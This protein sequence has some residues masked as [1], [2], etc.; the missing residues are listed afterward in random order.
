MHAHA[1][2]S[3]LCEVEVPYGLEA[4]A[5]DE[6]ERR[7]G[8]RVDTPYAVLQSAMDG[9]IRFLYTGDLM[10]LLTL[11]TVQTAS[12]VLQFAGPRP[13]ALLGDAAIR[14]MLQLI[15][16]IRGLWP[17][18]AFATLRLGTAGAESAVMTRLRRTLAAASGLTETTGSGD[19]EIRV[20]RSTAEISGWDVLI[21]VSPRPLATRA[22]RVCNMPGA[23]NAATARAMVLVTQP[24][25]N[26][27]FL[28][29]GCGSGTL[30]IERLQCAPAGLLA[31]IPA[32]GH[33]LARGGT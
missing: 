13:R 26:D 21:R 18:A 15:G 25:P 27:V 6:I 22:W 4:I 10:A 12:I 5:C 29:L 32:R 2:R 28:N 1:Q 17:R 16:A 7:L 24:R 3:F 31:A 9:R 33:S 11:G 23:L 14:A 20:R 8:A 19:L 30:L